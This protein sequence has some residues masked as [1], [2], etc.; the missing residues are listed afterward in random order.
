VSQGPV[1]TPTPIHR[2]ELVIE[3][4]RMKRKI[5]FERAARRTGA[6]QAAVAKAKEVG[7]GDGASPRSS[8]YERVL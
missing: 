2:L 6:A 1:V 3:M 7:P 5:K 8:E 4:T